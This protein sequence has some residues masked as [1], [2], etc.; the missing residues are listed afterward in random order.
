MR[1]R[2]G[3]NQ[4]QLHGHVFFVWTA[5]IWWE[6]L[7]FLVGK[8]TGP[9]AVFLELPSGKHTQNYGKSQFLMSKSTINGVFSIAM[10]VY[11]RVVHV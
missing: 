11:Q 7:W 3:S 1:L 9:P 4:A 2:S 6:F 5:V 8:F 10:L